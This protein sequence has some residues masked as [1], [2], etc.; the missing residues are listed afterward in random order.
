MRGA[1][2]RSATASA[3]KTISSHRPRAWGGPV[4]ALSFGPKQRTNGARAWQRVVLV[5]AGIKKLGP[6]SV[7]EC[8]FLSL[9]FFFFKLGLGFCN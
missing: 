7:S 8:G 2:R 4:A 1:Q 5:H 6:G 9:F 3:A